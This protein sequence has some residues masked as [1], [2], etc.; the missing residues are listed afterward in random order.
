MTKKKAASTD[1]T[2]T[3]GIILAD[4][5]KA[6]S[7]IAALLARVGCLEQEVNDLILSRR[8]RGFLARL[9]GRR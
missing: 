5:A 4:V 1:N 2:K 9:F 7:T 3:I 6:K 8:R